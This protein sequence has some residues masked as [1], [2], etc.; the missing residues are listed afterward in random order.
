MKKDLLKEYDVTLYHQFPSR[1]TRVKW[2]LC[3]LGIDEQVTTQDINLMQ[4]EQYRPSFLSLNRMGAVPLLVLDPRTTG[5]GRIAMSESCA[6][7]LFLSNY[8]PHI[9]PDLENVAATA[10]FQ[11][12]IGMCASSIDP[13]L[14]DVRRHEQ[15]LPR[16]K[17]V[18]GV[19]DAA[20]KQLVS[21]VVPTV[22]ALLQEAEKEGEGDEEWYV[23]M[24]FHAGLTAADVVLGYTL[25][26]ADMYGVNS[27]RMRR[28]MKRMLKRAS[29][30]RVREAGQGTQLGIP[31]DQLKEASLERLSQL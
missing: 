16:D 30:Q 10:K 17:R 8:F 18:Q 13:L 7:C 27:A 21:S 29:F 19:A 6:I 11:R 22:D 1:S 15:L 3:E 2:L 26:W 9:A 23:C 12:V 14:W 24:P 4:G 5:K 28:Y 25:Y 31:G 20:R